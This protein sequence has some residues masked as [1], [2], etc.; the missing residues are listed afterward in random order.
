MKILL[1][2]VPDAHVG[3]TT[4]DWDLEASN[5]GIFPPIGLMYLAGAIRRQGRHDVKILD[6]ILN[7]LTP[8]G[9]A[10]E[11]KAY[12]PDI[13]G[14]TVYTP[15]LFD[16]LQVSASLR[17]ALPN[18]RIVWGGPHTVLFPEESMT[19]Q[20]VDYLVRGEAEETFPAFCDALEGNT[21]FQQ[22]TGIFYR[23]NGEVRQT[24]EPGYVK[25]I[26]E[27]AF[28][29]VELV[30]Y[31]RY[32]SA[33]G[34]GQAVGTICSSRGCPFH[35]TF[36]AKLYSAYR[37]RTVENILEEMGLYYER[38]IR[39]FFFFDD[40]F[41]ASPRRVKEISN[42]I[43]DKGWQ[44]EW[45]F[46]GRVDAV[47]EEMLRVAKRAGCRQILFGVE[48]ATDEGFAAIKKKISMEQVNK[49]IRLC[50]E[51]GILSSTNWIIGFPHHKTRED[52]LKLIR[53]A[54]RL[55][56]DFAQFNICI[57]YH[58]T[59]IFQDG[60]QLG[61]F[62]PEIWRKYALNPE[63]NFAEPIWEEHLSR[64]ELSTLLQRC[65]RRFYLRPL[66]ILRK[67]MRLRNYREFKL[68]FNG[69]LT[70]LGITGYRRD[71]RHD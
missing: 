66:P 28:P 46:R 34:T 11:A 31:R 44:V 27:V 57:A 53:T 41:N 64:A 38:G 7:K 26:N 18:V 14:M 70:V 3:K 33:I 5:I 23:E 68:Y 51:I 25:N 24:G 63:P 20:T 12:Q 43:L 62:D 30:D 59:E 48:A 60:V 49:A 67:I 21:L 58:G 47:D 55:D 50:R 6:C 39:E 61:L 36:C 2:N 13:V 9:I 42:G 22:I 17:E 56:S 45:S 71:K 37:S 19:H 35:C 32:F 65:Y 4:D 15:T 40:L 29:A 1:L 16:A 54:V 52:I 69:A 8:D 10:Q